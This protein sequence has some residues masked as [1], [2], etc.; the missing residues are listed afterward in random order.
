MPKDMQ[1][2]I[3]GICENVT[4]HRLC[5]VGFCRLSK[6]KMLSKGDCASVLHVITR[7]LEREKEKGEERERERE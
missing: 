6:L 7:V 5:C 4:L 3:P 1:I 2:L